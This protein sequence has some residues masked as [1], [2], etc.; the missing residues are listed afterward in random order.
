MTFLTSKPGFSMKKIFTLITLLL[1]IANVMAQPISE[2][3]AREIAKA[4]LAGHTTRSSSSDVELEWSGRN[5][6]AT[7]STQ[8][9]TATNDDAL[10]YI[11]NRS[12]NSGFVI[13]AGQ[14][15]DTPIIAYSDDRGFDF[16]NMAESTREILAAWG[17]QIEAS[18][19]TVAKQKSAT[20]LAEESYGKVV[21]QYDT[22]LWDQGEPYNREC[23]VIDGYRAVTGCVATAMSIICYYNKWPERGTGTTQSYGYYDNYNNYR[24]VDSYT[25]GRT[26]DYSNMLFDYTGGYSTTEGNAVAALMH[27]MGYAVQMM[28][29]YVSS[30]AY[31]ENVARVMYSYFGYSKQAMLQIR[32][33]YNDDEWD[34]MLKANID[35]CGP[36]FY[37]GVGNSGGHAFIV[38]GYTNKNFFHFN[39]GWSGYNNGYY[40]TPEIEF[41]EGQDAVF[42]LIPDKDGTSTYRDFLFLT[43]YVIG[44]YSF[45]GIIC[46]SN[47]ITPNSPFDIIAGCIWNN[48]V[49]IFNGEIAVAIYNENDEIKEIIATST[50]EDLSP[51]YLTYT[52]FEGVS[53]SS[54]ID[55]GDK[56]RIIYKGENSTDWYWMQGSSP[57]IVDEILLRANASTIANAISLTY[58]KI[59]DRNSKRSLTIA[60]TRTIS[61]ECKKPDGSILQSGTRQPGYKTTI[62]FD[63]NLSGNFTLTF[64]EGEASYS[65][66]LRL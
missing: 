4:F 25:L 13:I 10:L 48:G 50:L 42:D 53:I 29:H 21:C 49:D 24:Y 59:T 5:P 6:Y 30:G 33:R 60:T 43:D 51:N 61:F 41:Y 1:I 17:R 7:P 47:S 39:F 20:T 27:D 66:K 35:K 45:N 63:N 19:P 3:R 65:I 16:D 58:N 26:Y 22:A 46:D 15:C 57:S 56:L 38:D 14:E 55:E 54:N 31:S 64:T 32:D 12:N 34:S 62:T 11:Y 28:Y 36:T 40:R 2:S 18:K 9:S 23:P 44:S 8:A 37:S 52:I